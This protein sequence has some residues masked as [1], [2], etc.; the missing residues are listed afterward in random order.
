MKTT[1]KTIFVALGAVGIMILGA[2]ALA[3]SNISFSPT[4][5][6]VKQGE[7]FNL[8]IK[9]NPQSVRNYTIKAEVK[10]PADILE[11]KSFA[12]GSNWMAIPQAGYDL[13]DNQNGLLIKTAGYP[14]GF[15]DVLTFGVVEFSAKKTG[16]GVIKLGNDS[17]ILDSTNKNTLADFSAQ[18]AQTNVNIAAVSAPAAAPKTTAKTTTPAAE[19]K[20]TETEETISTE[21]P[22][23]SE[24][25]SVSETTEM[26]EQPAEK[27]MFLAAI[28]GIFTLRT[29][30]VWVSVIVGIAVLLLLIYIISYL[31]RRS[32]RN[33]V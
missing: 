27:G 33:N 29:G 28:G 1:N 15:S 13:V 2:P 7:V 11:V 17:L 6:S 18:T 8:T 22:E 31:L 9:A 23:V 4:S 3:A 12:F 5:V 19:T 14:A 25:V 10:Y 20:T 30:K 26:A 16:S 21:Q 24:T 32:K